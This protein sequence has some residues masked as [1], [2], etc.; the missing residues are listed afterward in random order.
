MHKSCA[1]E[2]NVE[3]AGLFQS[4]INGLWVGDIK[5]QSSDTIQFRQ[6]GKGFFID[7]C[8]IDLRAFANIGLYASPANSLARRS[9]QG[10]FPASRLF[11]V[12]VKHFLHHG[13]LLAFGST[14]Q[15]NLTG[16]RQLPP[17]SGCRVCRYF[18][19]VLRKI[20]PVVF[21]VTEQDVFR[22]AQ[23]D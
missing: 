5:V 22:F 18:R 6:F 12:I 2:Q 21:P 15:W 9:Y 4:Q 23:K 10:F 7:V 11:S 8:G 17:F 16:V 1:V 3:R 14:L 20:L 13:P 19:G